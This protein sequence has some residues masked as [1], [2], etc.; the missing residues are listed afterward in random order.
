MEVIDQ[1]LGGTTP[2]D[3]I[4]DFKAIQEESTDLNTHEEFL[5]SFEDEF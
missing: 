4:I 5:D 2:L 3:I 1:K